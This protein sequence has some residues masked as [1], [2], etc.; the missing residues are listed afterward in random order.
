MNMPRRLLAATIAALLVA[1]LAAEVAAVEVTSPGFEAFATDLRDLVPEAQSAA[2][3]KGTHADG[4]DDQYHP[5][6]QR[7]GI[8][9]PESD[10]A[11]GASFDIEMTAAVSSSEAGSGGILNCASGGTVCSASREGQPAGTSFH[12]YAGSTRAP[13]VPGAGKRVEFGVV[14]LD[15]TPRDGRPSEGWE[16]IPEFP[17]DFFIG[18]NVGWTLLSANGEA[19]RLLRL[20]YGPGDPGFLAA[21]TDA[22][23][24]VRGSSW[25]ILVPKAEWDGTVS[26]RQFVFL[27]DRG[28]TS[29][30]TSVVDTYPDIFDAPNRATGE[31]TITIESTPPRGLPAGLLAALGAGVLVLVVAGAWLALRSRRGR[32]AL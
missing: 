7:P 21:P 16:A 3:A 29:P 13:L 23:A 15:Q 6:G 24:I 19:F 8:T 25:A 30:E 28:D 18:S 22:V 17:G 5:S 14:G 20:E 26:D 9:P 12:V 32:R 2:L 11:L 31:P 4:A 10:I 27:A 1:P